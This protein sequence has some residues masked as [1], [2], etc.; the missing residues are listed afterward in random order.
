MRTRVELARHL[1]DFSYRLTS[2]HLAG[3]SI[4][5]ALFAPEGGYR[6]TLGTLKHIAGW[7]HVYRSYAFESPPRHWK[8]VDWP[9]GLRDTI[10]P[11]QDY[12]DEVVAWFD[13]SH[14][15]WM[16]SLEPL[17]DDDMDAPRLLH[18][19]QQAPL[20]DIVTII[21]SHHVYHAGELN[22]LL[23]IYKGEAW[24]EMEEVEENHI[25]TIGHRVKPPWL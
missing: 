1:L 7:S 12:F 25:S 21:A 5:Q 16:A 17:T 11:T 18:W 23:S 20:F 4:E 15:N 22:Q 6:S 9:R 10:E 13:R 19:R 2:D 24:E 14:Q 3:L 8:F